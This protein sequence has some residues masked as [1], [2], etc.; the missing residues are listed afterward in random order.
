[1]FFWIFLFLSSVIF[2]R[3]SIL[4]G[5]N[6]HIIDRPSPNKIHLNPIPRSG[7]LGIFLSFVVGLFLFK[8][9]LSI[10]VYEVSFLTFIF[11][12][13]F[14]DD[15]IS[16]PQ[17][18]K[19]ITE[20]ALALILSIFENWKF[21]GIYFFDLIFSVF[22]LVGSINALNEIDGMDGLAGGVAFFTSIFLSY[23]LKDL[24]LIVAVSCLGFLLWNF[25]PA[26]VFMG[27][28]GSLFLGGF[29]GLM[30]L[31]V[32]E[33]KPSFSTLVALIFV[34]GIPMYDS[35]LTIIRR[36][37]RKKSIFIPDL[38]HFYNKLFNYLQRYV[39]TIAIIYIF[40]IILGFLG[41][42]LFNIS[43]IISIIIGITVWLILFLFS[44]K[45]GFLKE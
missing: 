27:D 21:T 33:M 39:L 17:K 26:K 25:H 20:I 43:S 8:E 16:I 5:K 12:L 41:I 45:L 28:G 35:A 13:G 40:S 15:F 14:V 6:F 37:I 44:Y 34:Y 2:V 30:S 4:I 19:F 31:K 3:L 38:G 11:L 23:W 10:N 9:K 24:T 42:F 18:I 1:M 32:L 36:L 29:I 22:Y 7:G